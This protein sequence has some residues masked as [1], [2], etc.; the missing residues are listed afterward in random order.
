MKNDYSVNVLFV[1]LFSLSSLIL[2]ATTNNVAFSETFSDIEDC[3][4]SITCPP[5]QTESA[6]PSCTFQIPDY[7][8]LATVNDACASPTFTQNPPAG[9]MVSLGA[10]TIT[11]SA[12]DGT[13]SVNCD[14]DILVIDTTSPTLTCPID[15]VEIFDENCQFV[16]LDYT[17]LGSATDSCSPGSIPITQTPLPGTVVSG[18]TTI[19]LFATDQAGNT[20]ACTFDIIASDITPPTI[21]C[22][23]DRDES[24]NLNCEFVIP[25]YSGLATANDNCGT[26]TFSQIPIPGTIV[27]LGVT[28]ITMS[29]TDGVNSS[30]CTFNITVNDNSPPIVVCPENQL[31]DFDINCEFILPDYT[32]MAVVT[33]A[34]HPG[35]YI[36]SQTPPE[37]TV[38]Y[39]NTVVTIFAEDN[40]GNIG[41]CAFQVIQN[42]VTPPVIACPSN[43][44]EEVN[45]DNCMFVVPDYSGLAVASDNCN[46]VLIITQSPAAGSMVGLGT[47]TI[48]L[49]ANDLNN[50]TSCTFD[51]LVEDTTA[52]N[53]VCASPFNVSLDAAGIATITAADVDGGSTDF[54]DISL[55]TIDITSFTCDD[56]GP[57][58]VT[59]TVEDNYGNI[60]HCTTTVNVQDPLFVC[61]QP[62]VALC[63]PVIVS[64]NENCEGE[65]TAADFDAGSFDPDGMA[66]IIT[67]SPEGP[68]PLG[69]TNITLTIDDGAFVATCNT[70]I[71]VEDTTPPIM[72]CLDNQVESTTINCEFVIPD[73]RLQAMAS[74]NC[75]TLTVTQIP[76]PGTVVSLGTTEI[77]ITA[78]DGSNEIT[79]SFDLSVVDNT[80]PTAICQNITIQLDANGI[81]VIDANDIN[82]GSTDNCGTVS[83]AISNSTF[84]CNDI[85]ENT[86]VFTITDNA[87]LTSECNAIV[88]VED[89]IAPQVV[90]QNV[91]VVLDANNEAQITVA[92]IDAGSTDNCAIVEYTLDIIDFDCSMVGDNEVTLT[93]TDVSGNTSSCLAIVTVEDATPPTMTCL[94]NQ[95]ESTTMNCE[96]VIPDYRLQAMASDNCNTLTVT[97][98]PA[99]GTVVS[100]GT[101]EIEITA[102]DGSNEIT[103]SFDL[104]VVDNTTP[105]AICQ[106]ITI[107]LDANGIAVIDANDINGGSIDNCGTVSVAI[108][109]T[110]FTCNDIG[111]N[112]I[113]FT[114]TDNAGLTSEC[115]AIVTVED[116]IAPQVVCQN[117]TVVLDANNE[118]Q[119]TVADID[120]GSTDNCAIVEYTLDI[121]DFDCSM[122]GDNEVTLTVTD[123]SGNVSNC[124]AIVTVQDTQLPV[125]I[126]QNITVQLDEYGIATISP[127]EIDNGSTDNC[128]NY[129]L[130]V[131][132]DTFDC[133]NLGA[134]EVFFT[135]T[136]VQGNTATCL[137]I[138]TVEDVL[139]PV[140]NCQNITRSLNSDYEVFI[141]IYDIS[142]DILDN[143]SIVSTEISVDT[144]NCSNLGEN[145]VTIV[146]ID[147]SGNEST[148][149]VTVMIEE[150]VFAPNAVCESVTVPLQQDGTATVMAINFDAG[151]TGTRC[152]NPFS[153][154]RDFFTC[155]DIGAPIQIEFTVY[156]AAG[157]TD[158]CIAFVNVIDGLAP[159]VFCPENQSVVS[160]GPYSLPDYF[161]TGEAIATDNCSSN[162]I[163]SQD[164]DPGTLLEQGVHTITLTAEDMN[165]FEEECEFTVYID[166]ILGA[167]N[168][169]VS[170]ETLIMYPNPANQIINISNPQF[171]DI[172]EVTIYD[173]SGRAIINKRISEMN[174]LLTIDVSNLQSATYMVIITTNKGQVVKQL[175]KE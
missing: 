51:I 108:S 135:I 97:Q 150:G 94:D 69:I 155:D 45:A 73:Y 80:A 53:A 65:A 165:G 81:A 171:I 120:A 42:D 93:V 125:A 41:S 35:P 78:N 34:C 113:V 111:E 29:A 26:P 13:N 170:L 102:N 38:I 66:T 95:V 132:V 92:D 68:Y 21:I 174:E 72:T 27:G 173:I 158:T 114:V 130:S 100:L 91:T 60:S 18:T 87:G 54:C 169:Q 126:C 98:I 24:A 79:C 22:P 49:T 129:T 163:T 10:Y 40:V 159:Q 147:Q 6:T 140:L 109:N 8:G 157:E 96:F 90:C 17:S 83:V 142:I 122:V 137:S 74:D 14:F 63:Q 36:L 104:S 11:I 151:S 99:P 1:L 123:F 115:N 144:F 133:S 146:A 43:Q 61:N 160:N 121:T 101:T 7:T 117:V 106:N 5:N 167:D 154:D 103:C 25:D 119:I 57:N 23:A 9:T 84:T 76:A 75:N 4:I 64:A 70:T 88:T 128:A 143:C 46:D 112:T 33:D 20:G 52:P 48:T 166:D 19:F 86:V 28:L 56:L 152:F 162:V 71:T 110:T 116:N 50:Q 16:L 32:N 59:L 30:P 58:A 55:M 12:D 67:V 107:Q 149:T 131:D 124:T 136:D 62:P 3:N 85:G 156:N 164:P 134:N 138:V 148:C 153:I 15:Q 82:G 172:K 118:A 37:G 175:A 39:G 31:E 139:P 161:A 2:N 47:T 44:T 77:E 141:D 105:T 168:P 89:N 127:S 145:E